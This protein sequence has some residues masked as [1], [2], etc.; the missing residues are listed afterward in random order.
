MKF[1]LSFS[2]GK[3][4]EK[5]VKDLV[6]APIEA[7]A[8]EVI[9]EPSELKTEF[10]SKYGEAIRRIFQEENERYASLAPAVSEKPIIA[11]G[12]VSLYEGYRNFIPNS[13]AP[14][15]T[16][17]NF[18]LLGFIKNLSIWNPHFSMAL[19]NIVTLGNT[20]YEID[21]GQAI[22]ENQAAQY[23]KFLAER[24]E[25][26]YEFADGEDSLDNDL[27]AQLCN[28]G[29]ISA[30]A[31]IRP[32]LRGIQNIVRVDPEFVRFAYD[33][34]K[35]EHVPLQEIGGMDI[36]DNSE[37]KYPGYIQLNTATY[38]Y[39]G[40]MRMGEMP[41]AIPPFLA[42]LESVFIENDMVKNF[43]NMMKRL[44][45]MGFLSV[46]VNAPAIRQ[47][48]SQETYSNRL[49]AYLEKL[50]PA[51]EKGFSRGIVMGYKDTHEF[52]V[53]APM[54][55]AAADQAM[56]MIQSLVFAGL[57]QD[58]NM[59]GKNN[60]VTE[61]FG[62]VLLEKMT[63]QVSNKQ[64]T[65]G[66]FKSRIFK[67]ELLLNG[68]KV[69]EL[70]VKYKRAATADDKREQEIM[71]L[72]INNARLLFQ[73]GIIDQQKR[74]EMLGFDEPA[75]D[76]PLESEA[77]KIAKIKGT[78]PKPGKASNSIERIKKKLKA[79]LPVFDYFVPDE[80]NPLTLVDVG[81]FPEKDMFRFV[82]QYLMAADDQ[83]KQA[84]EESEKDIA[85]E[86]DL[87]P[88][89]ASEDL[90][91]AS[92]IFG[93]LKN[94]DVNYVNP[95]ADIVENNIVSIYEHF[96]KDK[97]IFTE[98]E[99]FSKPSTQSYFVIPDALFD[100]MDYRAIEF[101]ENLDKIYLGKFI[102]D[103]DTERRIIAWLRAKFQSGDVPIGKNSSLIS[104]FIREFTGM[105]EL[106]AWKIRR[107]IE[108]TVNRTR[109]ISN[110]KYLQ[111][112]LVVEYEVVEVMDDKTC[113]WCR[114]MNRKKFSVR[115]TV[116]KYEK[117]FRDG[118]ERLPDYSPFATSIK[119]DQFV[120]MDARQIQAKNI[121]LPSYH[122]HCRGR[123]V[124]S[125]KS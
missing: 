120:K 1:R 56:N 116:D 105:V 4:K 21:F 28:Y 109:S 10:E 48:E 40:M 5:A 20:D 65:L 58:P 79:N 64:R 123:I 42:A 16:N 33:P 69:P 81:D 23:K 55:P 91:M 49:T 22:G 7:Q 32:D 92:M 17:F 51:A 14:V 57:K 8:V 63:H 9:H 11:P 27:L 71:T 70:R 124:A 104:E 90:V 37:T 86:F 47:G 89:N 3:K 122:P 106:E 82:K 103:P 110:A 30:E 59:H 46:L 101:L 95:V 31:V 52:N 62:R 108:T 112:A 107:I 38:S 72:K 24:V 19:E 45:M 39:I 115:E 36:R 96:R 102:T 111:Q 88:A 85:Q 100:L 41:Y 29:A 118:I 12:R 119:I 18:K 80:C 78:E 53:H 60:S 50:R 15:P 66:T 44:G 77:E 121:N 99:G 98:S 76:E 114:H 97:S 94:W 93:L 54:N 35:A 73:D 26:W 6:K 67:L 83:F 43:Q 84:L 117:L 75:E 68:I 2:S 25:G 61:T 87:L 125:F 34:A 113:S 74:A 13:N